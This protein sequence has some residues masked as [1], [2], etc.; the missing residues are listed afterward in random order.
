MHLV[1]AG[2][3]KETFNATQ[4]AVNTYI[5]PGE[6]ALRLSRHELKDLQAGKGQRFFVTFLSSS[7]S[8][9]K[10]KKVKDPGNG[11]SKEAMGKK[12]KRGNAPVSDDDYFED[13]VDE[14]NTLGLY[15]DDE[16]EPEDEGSRP[17]HP[18]RRRSSA[19]SS[20][21]RQRTERDLSSD[22]DE[23]WSFT[24]SGD[25]TTH[26]TTK[27]AIQPLRHFSY[28]PSSSALTKSKETDDVPS[29]ASRYGGAAA[30]TTSAPRPA[31]F[32]PN[33]GAS[34]PVLTSSLSRSK[35]MSRPGVESSCEPKRGV[36]KPS[37]SSF[38]RAPFGGDRT[39]LTSRSSRPT[40]LREVDDI[41]EINSETE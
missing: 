11:T 38:A 16:L 22:V 13:F 37:T 25:T 14:G 19:A 4:Y 18:N 5:S 20:K 39:N 27:S 28:D 36:F 24:M 35:P 29:S 41:I 26:S 30:S 7:A 32:T 1:L 31:A 2:Y 33:G 34:K 23:D 40:P 3:L 8:A 17:P 15:A 10:A 6:N 12:R 9:K 21:S